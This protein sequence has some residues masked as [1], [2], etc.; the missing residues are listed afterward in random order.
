MEVRGI[1]S[2]VPRLML[3]LLALALLLASCTKSKVG[4]ELKPTPWGASD[5]WGQTA[6]PEEQLTPGFPETAARLY[7]AL[8]QER[9]K[10]AVSEVEFDQF[11]PTVKQ[12]REE[13]RQAVRSRVDR[14]LDFLLEGYAGKL[15]MLRIYRRLRN[16]DEYLPALHQQ[17]DECHADLDRLF[18]V[19]PMPRLSVLGRHPLGP[20]IK[21]V[22]RTK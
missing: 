12:Q 18:T 17:L 11:Q 4:D 19:H 16:G 9:Q 10:L 15:E 21:P 7:S 20:C 14:D 22:P 13:T 8:E 2:P 1:R 5:Y 6:G 3:E